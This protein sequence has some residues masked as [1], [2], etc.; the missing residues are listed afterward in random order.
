MDT[1]LHR[2]HNLARVLSVLELSGVDTAVG[3]AALFG[4]IVTPLKIG[5]MLFGAD[6]P[7]LF[8]RGLEHSLGLPRGWMD[9]SRPPLVPSM[10]STVLRSTKVEEE[11]VGAVAAEA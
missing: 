9:L 2:H 5:R 8:A 11:I 4:H 1:Q 3:Q 10:I 7:S 6:V